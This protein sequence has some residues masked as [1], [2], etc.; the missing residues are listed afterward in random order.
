MTGYDQIRN[1]KSTSVN[2]TAKK[3]AVNDRFNPKKKKEKRER[4]KK[5]KDSFSIYTSGKS[6]TQVS[7]QGA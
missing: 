7:D 6:P 1:C 2:R 4:T 5:K 3:Q